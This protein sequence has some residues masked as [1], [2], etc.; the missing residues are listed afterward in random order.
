MNG[1]LFVSASVCV[2]FLCLGLESVSVLSA[3]GLGYANMASGSFGTIPYCRL[4][5]WNELVSFEANLCFEP[6]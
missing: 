1:L 5:S 3:L 6:F 2:S 4:A